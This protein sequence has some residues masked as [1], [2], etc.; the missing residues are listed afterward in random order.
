MTVLRILHLYPAELG[1]NGDAG[2]VLALAERARWRGIDA[3]IVTHAPGAAGSQGPVGGLQSHRSMWLWAD[4]I[5]QTLAS[6]VV[7]WPSATHTSTSTRAV[8]S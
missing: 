4:C 6:L 7:S 2:N 5:A 3:E 1:I 8:S